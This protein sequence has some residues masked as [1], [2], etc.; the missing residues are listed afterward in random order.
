ML[1]LVSLVLTNYLTGTS[2]VDTKTQ[3]DLLCKGFDFQHTSLRDV[4]REKA[5]D[6]TYLHAKF[7]RDCLEEDVNVPTQLA[8]SLL[9][10]K[11]NEGRKEGKSWSL[12]EGFP[13]SMEQILEFKK[14]VSKCFRMKRVLL[15][16]IG[17]KIKLR[18]VS[19]LL[20]SGNA[21]T[22]PRWR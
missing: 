14:K 19:E 22:F 4:L 9:E 7:V 5:A 12:V 18:T 8:I 2:G 6:Q 11:I 10:L 13:E 17:A 20:I 15:I 16:S 21:E 1:V 3:C